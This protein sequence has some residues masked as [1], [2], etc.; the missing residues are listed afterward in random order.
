M[1]GV[2]PGRFIR[3]EL[4]GWERCKTALAASLSDC[5]QPQAA[6][7]PLLLGTPCPSRFCFVQAAA[8]ELFFLRAVLGAQGSGQGL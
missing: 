8:R 1:G 6:A 3:G 7:E 2:S 5:E 4:A